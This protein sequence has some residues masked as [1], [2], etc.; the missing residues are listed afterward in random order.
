[1]RAFRGETVF[2]CGGGEWQGRSVGVRA[3]CVGA[4]FFALIFLDGV[5]RGSGLCE[6]RAAGLGL[7]RPEH[8]SEHVNL[9]RR[10]FFRFSRKKRSAGL[11]A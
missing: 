8:C 4:D 6:A 1:V 9:G 7:Q 2:V 3:S 5:L 11:C 10:R